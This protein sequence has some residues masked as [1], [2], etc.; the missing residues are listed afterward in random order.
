M[1]KQ[2]YIMLFVQQLMYKQLTLFNIICSNI[3]LEYQTTQPLT[4]GN[5]V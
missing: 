3:N 4:R 5:H 2:G 1:N